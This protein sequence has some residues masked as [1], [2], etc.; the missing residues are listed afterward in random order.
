MNRCFES[1]CYGYLASKFKLK[2]TLAESVRAH[3][4]YLLK[5]TLFLNKKEQ[6]KKDLFNIFLFDDVN[7][8]K[9]LDVH[10]RFIRI[11]VYNYLCKYV[12]SIALDNECRFFLQPNYFHFIHFLKSTD[13]YA[14]NFQ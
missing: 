6:I 13:W 11:A 3:G 4:Q 10:N 1:E 2:Y 14:S 7:R 8:P 12:D 9:E 5:T